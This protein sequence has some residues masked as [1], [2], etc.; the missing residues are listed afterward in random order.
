MEDQPN[1]KTDQRF[2]GE[3]S[4]SS[5]VVTADMMAGSALVMALQ[6]RTKNR[7]SRIRTPLFTAPISFKNIL[8]FYREGKFRKSCRMYPPTFQL[9][10]D[11]GKDLVE[12][13]FVAAT[14]YRRSTVPAH[15]R[16][17]I[18]LRIL[19]GASYGEL[20]LDYQVTESTVFDIFTS[21]CNALNERLRLEG[22]PKTKQ[23]LQHIAQGF[24]TSPTE[25]SPGVWLC[26]GLAWHMC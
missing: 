4:E 5:V 16:S 12:R 26:W 22:L 13:K 1:S 14:E 23:A 9:L 20:S 21:P 7:N 2:N 6:L 18:T 10:L 19:A 25:T 17:A 3:R 15:I 8:G 24:Q 11:T